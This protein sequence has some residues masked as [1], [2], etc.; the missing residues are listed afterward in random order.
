ME[1]ESSDDEVEVIAVI[2]PKKKL[3]KEVYVDD[4]D[5]E[6]FQPKSRKS[7]SLKP[8]KV[9]TSDDDDLSSISSSSRINPQFFTPDGIV[10]SPTDGVVHHSYKIQTVSLGEHYVALG[11]ELPS[12]VIPSSVVPW[13]VPRSCTIIIDKEKIKCADDVTIDCWWWK[14]SKT[15]AV[16]SRL[17]DGEFS[18]VQGGEDLTDKLKVVRRTYKSKD[19]D[20]LKKIITAT[21]P[22]GANCKN[23]GFR[24]ANRF[25]VIEYVWQGKNKIPVPE[26]TKKRIYPSVKEG[27]QKFAS[28]GGR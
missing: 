24:E 9:E 18:K 17:Q 10:V 1:H 5:D 27:V 14:H 8:L 2:A 23:K 16:S 25:V 4:S 20:G 3:T 7:S 11:S 12:V 6:D 28:M 13:H 15:Y 26:N 21:Y 19:N 22:R